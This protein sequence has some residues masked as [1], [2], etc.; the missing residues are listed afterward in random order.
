MVPTTCESSST[1]NLGSQVSNT[2]KL[3]PSL[4]IEKDEEDASIQ[5][6]PVYN[7]E[8]P[9]FSLGLKPKVANKNT[10]DQYDAISLP[11]VFQCSNS[12][13]PDLNPNISTKGDNEVNRCEYVLVVLSESG[14]CS[15]PS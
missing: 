2:N 15:S 9:C 14:E 13:N 11:E 3:F 4:I 7:E 6:E 8:S 1:R 10:C 12:I 5:M